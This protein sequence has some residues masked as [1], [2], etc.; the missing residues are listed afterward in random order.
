[1]LAGAAGAALSQ[2]RTLIRSTTGPIEA[3]TQDGHYLAWAAVGGSKCNVV[4]VLGPT[5]GN[6]VT[7]QPATGSMTCHWDLSDGTMQLAFASASSTALWTLHESGDNPVDYVM[8]AQMGGSEQ[9][10]DRLAHASDGTGLW[11]GGVV[12][13]G[14]TLAYS[15]VDVEYADPLGCASGGSCRKTIAGGGIQL[16]ALGSSTP[17]PNAKPA[18]ELAAANGLLAYVPAS[19]VDKSGAPKPGSNASIQVVDATTGAQCA[20]VSSPGIP[21]AIALS[22]HVLAVL[23]HSNGSERLVWYGLRPSSTEGG[24]GCSTDATQLG[25]VAV[26]S[27]TT[28]QLAASDR[29]VVYRVGQALRGVAVSTG[30][31]RTL[32]QVE[33]TPVGLSLQ[34]KQIA[35]AE[36]TSSAGR[37]RALSLG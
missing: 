26:S 12:G 25:S 10:V 22:S 18:L 9:K 7:P 34:A 16:V 36:N 11:L 3:V 23:A 2:P 28:P 27:R 33:G 5:G 15:S 8:T 31:V 17:L 6:Q 14:G 1:M 20:V 19:R 37:I 32:A 21:L 13:A 35:W 4:R 29:L 30:V 24:P